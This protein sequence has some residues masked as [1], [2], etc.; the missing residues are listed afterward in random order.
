M[1]LAFFRWILSISFKKCLVVDANIFECTL[2]FS[3][4]SLGKKI[5]MI[6]I[7]IQKNFSQ[8]LRHIISLFNNKIGFCSKYSWVQMV[9]CYHNCSN[10][11]WEKIVL[12]WGKKSESRKKFANSRPKGREF[13]MFL[14]FIFFPNT[15]NIFFPQ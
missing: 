15:K 3:V 4:R 14:R 13:V 12:V 6:Y 2:R 9:F 7:I 10:V 1:V 8:I 11:L 5:V